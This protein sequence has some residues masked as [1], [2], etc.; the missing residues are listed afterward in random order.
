MHDF[1]SFCGS[2]Y[3][4]HSGIYGRSSDFYAQL[5]ENCNQKRNIIH[6]ILY[7]LIEWLEKIERVSM[8]R[9]ELTSS[10]SVPAFATSFTKRTMHPDKLPYEVH[11]RHFVIIGARTVHFFTQQLELQS[12]HISYFPLLSYSQYVSF[13]IYL[14]RESSPSP[15]FS[16]DSTAKLSFLPSTSHHI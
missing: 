8:L 3:V 1:C 9:F 4:Q 6:Y 13:H 2:G 11:I 10:R 5:E 12:C 16:L 15:T 14:I 7:A